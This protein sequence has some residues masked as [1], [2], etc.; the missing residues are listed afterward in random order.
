MAERQAAL[1]S[2]AFI[3]VVGCGRLGAHVASRLSAAG[4]G[5]VVVDCR[6]EAFAGL[7]AE[8]SGFRVEGDA[9]EMALLR[10]AKVEQADMV[11]AA[12]REDNVNLMVAQIALNVLGTR[13]V[14]ARVTDPHRE[15][16]FRELGIETICPTTLGADLLLKS[17]S[18][19]APPAGSTAPVAPE[20]R[21]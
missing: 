7:S 9:T 15:A 8:F 12:T 20:G 10:K 3:V 5:V 1:R 2:D 14:V 19:P 18:E 13:R 11:I 17:L 16:V 21:P 4:C 6:E